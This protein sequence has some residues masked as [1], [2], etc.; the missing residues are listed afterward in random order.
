MGRKKNPR[1]LHL[2]KYINNDQ[3]VDVYEF[4]GKNAKLI[5][6]IKNPNHQQPPKNES[7]NDKEPTTMNFN[8]EVFPSPTFEVRENN[9]IALFHQRI[10]PFVEFDGFPSIFKANNS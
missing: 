2:I 10:M 7:I 8:L 6:V 1:T 9:E 3:S 5:Q 4:N